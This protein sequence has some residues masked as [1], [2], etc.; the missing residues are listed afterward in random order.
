MCVCV[1]V[2]V[3][4]HEYHVYLDVTISLYILIL[5][6]L[7]SHFVTLPPDN[8]VHRGSPLGV[9]AYVLDF[10]LEPDFKLYSH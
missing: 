6:P 4:L 9:M 2:C 8:C 5:T 7:V 10:G 1:C 3:S